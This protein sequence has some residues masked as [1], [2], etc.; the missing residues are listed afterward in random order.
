[1][2]SNR[3][4]LAVACFAVAVTAASARGRCEEDPPYPFFGDAAAIAEGRTVYRT[5]CYICHLSHGG[6]GPNLFA[7]TLSPGQFAATV[8]TGRNTMP[9]IGKLLTP[10]QIWKV[11]A[12]VRSTDKYE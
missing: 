12:F 3:L 4:G 1:M 9:A 2:A 7:S 6:R 10:E 8:I 11:H 5:R